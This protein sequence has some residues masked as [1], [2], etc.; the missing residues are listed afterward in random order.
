MQEPVAV[1]PDQGVTPIGSSPV[2]REEDSSIVAFVFLP[3]PGVGD[4]LVCV[5]VG[6][7]VEIMVG[8]LN[9]EAVCAGTGR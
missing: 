9:G 6:E 1:R 7:V 5:V 2:Q 3:P 8:D 4:Q